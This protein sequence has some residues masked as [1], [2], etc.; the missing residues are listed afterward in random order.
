MSKHT[1]YTEVFT[2]DL[3]KK[4][5]EDLFFIHNIEPGMKDYFLH[6][7][8]TNEAGDYLYGLHLGIRGAAMWK[9]D[10]A[11]YLLEWFNFSNL[12]IVKA[13]TEIELRESFFRG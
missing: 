7:E 5:S 9:Y 12:G 8:G 2:G 3:T 1:G 13:K 4:V 10:H 6:P 11:K